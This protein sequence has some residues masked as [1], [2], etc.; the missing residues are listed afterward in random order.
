[1]TD[2]KELT[3]KIVAGLKR[4]NPTNYQVELEEKTAYQ[5]RF[6]NNDIT[7]V[8]NWNEVIASIFM[9]KEKKIIETEIHNV[10]EK[11]INS[12]I[13]NLGKV[14]TIIPKNPLFAGLAKGPFDYSSYKAIYEKDFEKIFEKGPDIAKRAIDAS[15]EAGAKRSAGA[16]NA[17]ASKTYL[18]TS[19]DAEVE[20]FGTSFYMHIRSFVNPEASG[21]G[22]TAGVLISELNPEKAGKSS[23]EKA[24]L[25]DPPL[26]IDPGK[27][28]VI[29]GRPALGNLLNYTMMFASAYSVLVGYSCFIKKIGQK[30][31]SEL[32]TL[33]DD[34]RLPNGINSSKSDEEGVPT[35]ETTIIENGI[36][37]T[38]LHNTSTAAYFKTETTGN[39]GIISPEPWNIILEK[40]DFTEEELISD[41]KKGVYIENATYTRFQNPVEGTFSSILRDGIFL[42]ENGEIKQ[43]IK[44][45]RLSDSILNIMSS[46]DGI[47][48]NKEQVLHWWMENPVVTPVV[49]AR[50]IGI[51]RSTK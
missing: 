19:N 3:D 40:G 17:T 20:D 26:V 29:F 6:A 36:F 31:A 25:S 41:I 33:K 39:A 28:D 46:I 49:R 18:V 12:I 11:A 38:Y 37:K 35:Q 48:K 1:M 23:G 9:E 22:A 21:M 51:T 2:L 24:K 30:V 42:I 50:N 47:S 10:S 14:S 5:L 34:G 43:G 13:E 45:A 27:Y 44:G 7:V 16:L 8:K 32:V 4:Y 15:L